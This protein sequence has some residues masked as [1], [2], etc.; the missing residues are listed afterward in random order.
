[1]MDADMIQYYVRATDPSSHEQV[2]F[3]CSNID[4][5]HAKA[6][7]LRMRRYRDV[8][9]NQI[10]TGPDTGHWLF[11]SFLPTWQHMQKRSQV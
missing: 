6:A 3:A 8:R 7:E 4:L 11:I 10:F 9:L 5:A 1:M 2:A